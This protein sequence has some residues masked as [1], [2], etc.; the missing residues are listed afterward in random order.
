MTRRAG[1]AEHHGA[2]KRKTAPEFTLTSDFRFQSSPAIEYA[3]GRIAGSVKRMWE[4]S[5]ADVGRCSRG[6][7]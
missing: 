5:V 1:A 6:T 3:S 7:R 2:L 4:G